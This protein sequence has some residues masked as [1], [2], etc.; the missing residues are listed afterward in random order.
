MSVLDQHVTV[1][2]G[3]QDSKASHTVAGM[4]FA[5]ICKFGRCAFR[6]LQSFYIVCQLILAIKIS[7]IGW[8]TFI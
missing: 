7:P 5:T 4:L 3:Q 2:S 8:K 6:R 1:L